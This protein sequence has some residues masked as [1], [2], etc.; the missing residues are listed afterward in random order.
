MRRTDPLAA[1]VTAAGGESLGLGMAKDGRVFGGTYALEI[2]T[3]KS[4]LP[5]TRG[6]SARGRGVV[7]LEGIA[8]RARRGDEPGRRL[9]ERLAADTDLVDKLKTVHFERIRVDPDGRAV[10]RHLGG[11]L[12]WIAFPPVVWRVF[13]QLTKKCV[14]S[15]RIGPPTA[16][17]NWFRRS[18]ALVTAKKLRASREL[19]RK[20][21]NRLPWKLLVPE[22][23]DM[24]ITP[25]AECPNSAA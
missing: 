16:A 14:L 9:A 24:V 2:S 7:K 22:R 23:V 15:L 8:F 10:I 4:V 17:P 13:S 3:G 11:S 18:G 20:Y 21:S 5:A 19:L 1:R 12:V 6:V 25:P